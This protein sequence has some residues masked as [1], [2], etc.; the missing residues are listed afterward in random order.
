ML[1]LQQIKNKLNSEEYSFLRESEH[2]GNNIILLTTGG[3]HAYGTDVETSDL[4]IRGIALERE[5]EILGLSNFE[6]FENNA[7]DTTIY[8]LKKVVGLLLNCN[9]NVVEM[10]GTKDEHLFILSEEGKLLRDNVDLFLS[11]KAM[12]SFGGYATA[13]LRRL[14]NALAR[15]NYPQVE[16][17]K[18]IFNSIMTQI[19]HLQQHYTEFT[20]EE[21]K[22]YIDKSNKEDYEEEIFMDIQLTHYPLRDFKNIYSEMGNVV[23]DYAK[24]NHRNKKKDDLHLNKHAMH[25]IRLLIMGTELL[26]G[27]GINTYREKDGDFLLGIRS[28][29]YQK[30]DGSFYSEFFEMIDEYEKKLK[31]A[32]D[33]SPLPSK[34]NFN[35][36]EE[37]VVEINRKN[38]MG[39]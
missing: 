15:D 5:K 35:K 10:L 32:A 11:K 7:T 19:K 14:Q 38:R 27:K 1:E 34:P 21:I 20:N 26:E 12:H 30:E 13:Q 9:P 8:G 16:K 6:Q 4:D 23:K 2:L 37:L 18:H 3:S 29:K 25:L 36:V 22:L 24:L 39:R 17:E 33:N 31:Y 28:G